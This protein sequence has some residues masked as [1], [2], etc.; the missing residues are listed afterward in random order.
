MPKVDDSA[1]LGV[2]SCS[3]AVMEPR[4]VNR[5]NPFITALQR[6]PSA[7]NVLT[8]SLGTALAQGF[9]ML[10]APILTR[11][12]SAADIGRLG[13][14]TSFLSVA[15]VATSFKY[16]LGIVSATDDAEAAQL[17]YASTVLSLVMS[18]LAGV[19][20]YL[21][22]HFGA[23]GFGTLPLYSFW[24]MIAAVFFTG[25]FAALRYWAL[26]EERFALLSKTSISQ[27]AAR[28]VSQAGLGFWHAN[29]AILLA[30]E[31]IGRAVG[32]ARMFRDVWP[33]I[34]EL[35]KQATS[36]DLVAAL[37]RNRKL[38]IYSLPSSL[39]DT[40]VANLPLPLV[41]ALYGSES[42]GQ[43]AVV[44]RVL[45]IPLALLASSVADTFHSELAVCARNNPEEMLRVF[46]RTSLNL[47]LMAFLPTCALLLWG[48]PLFEI[49]FGPGWGAAGTL[50][51]I[52]APW[53]LTQFIVSPLS[54]LVFVLRGQE[55]KLIY[56]IVLLLSIGALIPIARHESFTL[57]Q[58]VG[59]L[60]LV[61][62]VA[63]VIYYGVLVWIVSRSS[64]PTLTTS[65]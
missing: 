29:T 20:L 50:A 62:T 37:K 34:H 55:L 56:D 23:F 5:I 48:R 63:Y 58:T 57:T 8:L 16:E 10:S 64:R 24:L 59:A 49:V 22:I 60:S 54:R 43:L 3:T 30:G 27:G 19:L 32:L 17:T 53:F 36:G 61:N 4:A 33:R 2:P 6:W 14:F 42:G 65:K 9:G 13:L 47:F 15:A 7:K 1:R 45:A 26:R 38:A 18:A 35:R 46:K 44:Q 21:A 40:I 41:V 39:I 51:A 25:S 12:Y 28:A 31:L 11:L 52:C